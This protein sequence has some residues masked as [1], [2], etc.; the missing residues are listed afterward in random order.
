MLVFL[1]TSSTS[2]RCDSGSLFQGMR[3]VASSRASALEVAS[4]GDAALARPFDP[5]ESRASA[6]TDSNRKHNG[7]LACR[8]KLPQTTAMLPRT[9]TP[10]IAIPP[11]PH[12]SPRRVSYRGVKLCRS[13]RYFGPAATP[14][15]VKKARR[16]CRHRP[17]PFRSLALAQLSTGLARGSCAARQFAPRRPRQSSGA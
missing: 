5:A 7:E 15:T 11:S 17:S 13:D 4:A 14:A 3:R 16:V 2:W 9:L 10:V 8:A 12:C 6:T 1:T